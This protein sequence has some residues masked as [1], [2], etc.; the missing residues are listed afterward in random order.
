MATITAALNAPLP[1]RRL[2][3]F[4]QAAL[5][6]YW[7]GNGVHWAAILVFLLPHQAFLIGGDERKGTTAGIILLFT[8]LI[9]MVVAPFFGA[10]SD[11][12]RTPFGRRRPWL[13][14]GALVNALGLI[15][16]AFIPATPENFTLFIVAFMWI[17]FWNNVA[18]APYSALIPDVVPPPQRGSASGWF[19]IMSVLGNAVGGIIGAQFNTIGTESIYFILAAV[20]IWGML[21]TVLFTREPEPPK[22]IPPFRLGEFLRGLIDPLKNLNFRWV[23]I[24][25]FLVTMGQYTIQTFILFYF[26]DVIHD[27]RLFGADIVKDA[28]T[29]AFY[30]TVTLLLGALLSTLIA[31]ALSDK[32]GRKIMMYISGG[33][34]A[35]V[36]AVLIFTSDFNVAVIM[37]VVFGIGYGAYQSVD[38][39]L[40]SDVL[41]S[42]DDYAKD[43]GVW[44]IAFTAPQIIATPL[45]GFLLDNFQILG[46]ANGAPTLGYTVIFSLTA[47]YFFLGTVFVRRI[48]GVR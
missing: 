19:G 18:T 8:A 22:E 32:Y 34:Q 37:G 31:G 25:R 14:V 24:T 44:H 46:K 35:L 2:T 16:L 9:S 6:F 33:L 13:V 45:A 30:F 41:P 28:A 43:M 39:A 21:G 3:T 40:A 26:T 17:A 23:F 48:K 5:S 4:H 7:F 10:I 20:L 11:R 27:F 47:L 38:W 36:A 15:A 1:E 29:A 42:M 12:I